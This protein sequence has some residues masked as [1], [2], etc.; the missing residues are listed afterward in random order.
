MV[1]RLQRALKATL[2]SYFSDAWRSSSRSAPC[3]LCAG[4]AVSREG[5]SSCGASSS[6]SSSSAVARLL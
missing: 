5:S 3:D 4:V 2:G 1:E 6:S